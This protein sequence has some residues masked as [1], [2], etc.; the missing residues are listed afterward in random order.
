VG[1]DLADPQR[2]GAGKAGDETGEHV[3]GYRKN[4]QPGTG[5][6]LVGR[7]HRGCAE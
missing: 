3:V 7:Q 6:D 4:E 5:G 1:D 2:A